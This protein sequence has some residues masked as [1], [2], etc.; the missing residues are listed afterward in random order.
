MSANS[1][2]NVNGA[3]F[4]HYLDVAMNILIVLNALAFGL[5]TDSE[6]IKWHSFLNSFCNWSIVAFVIELIIK[7]CYYKKSFFVGDARG[8]NLFD[9]TIVL[10]SCLAS[11][12]LF[13]S[14][15]VFRIFRIFRQLNILRLIPSARQLKIIIEALLA[16]LPGVAWTSAFFFIII[17]TYALIGSAFFGVEFPEF[18]GNVWKSMYTLFQV[19][20]LE[21]WSMGVARPVISVY[22]SAWI[23]FVSYVIFSAF[24]ILNIIV[25]LVVN[26]LDEVKERNKQLEI[27]IE[28]EY[29]GDDI[30]T[31]IEEIEVLITEIK[32]QSLSKN[33]NN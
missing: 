29:K 21:S 4:M 22:P 2:Y 20:T 3:M 12:P 26:S 6:M 11:F 14:I 25:A 13:S 18:F 10:L 32:Q 24:I 23:Y 8:W 27:M 1:K 31:K 16:S 28:N 9:M 7:I 15:R 30:I 33:N 19:M 5:M 17:Y